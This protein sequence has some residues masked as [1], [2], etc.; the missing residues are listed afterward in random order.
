MLEFMLQDEG[1]KRLQEEC[2]LHL[3]NEKT[4][5]SYFERYLTCTADE[6]VDHN[7]NIV[8]RGFEASKLYLQ[9]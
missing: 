7:D 1:I 6:N 4:F 2:G 9:I 8:L 5:V 3:Q